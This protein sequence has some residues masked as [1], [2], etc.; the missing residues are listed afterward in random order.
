VCV[1]DVRRWLERIGS[2]CNFAQHLAR[3]ALIH[4][5]V[6]AP[7][8][9][10]DWVR[11]INAG[12]DQAAAER[13]TAIVI[14]PDLHTSNEIAAT[15]RALLSGGRWSA[16]W[17][18][19][20]V[21]CGRRYGMLRVAWRT[22]VA[23][24]RETSVMGLAPLRHMPLP[25]RAPYVALVLWPGGR[26]NRRAAI[27]ASP[28]DPVGLVDAAHALDDPAYDHDWTNTLRDVKEMLGYDRNTRRLLRD[29]A[30]RL[31]V[32]VIERHFPAP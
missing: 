6:A 25:R 3:K 29:V 12:L 27:P 22:S 26:E 14:F 31:P 9:T 18:A 7:E 24:G 10:R 8:P 32:S 17:I 28:L 15:V 13:K 5:L 21:G 30:F 2:G 11:A 4:Y 23:N 19:S 16:R 20:E 1:E